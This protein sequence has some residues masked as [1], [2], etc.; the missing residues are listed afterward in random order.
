MKKQMEGNEEQRRAAAREAR[1]NGNAPSE[2]GAT[3]GASKQLKRVE[4]SAS[5]QERL[6]TSREGKAN[7]GSGDQSKPGSRDR[8]PRR[9]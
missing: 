6:E 8:D 2:V 4:R 1:E 5:P 3:L 9:E 7:P